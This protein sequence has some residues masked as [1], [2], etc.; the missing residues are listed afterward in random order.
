MADAVNP[1]FVAIVLAFVLAVPAS[2]R[3]AGPSPEAVVNRGVVELETGRAAGI[4][5][6]IAED[7]AN[8]VDDG[9]TRRVLPVIGAGTWQN[10]TDLKL[11]RGID[12]AI[13]QADVLDYARQ[14]NLYP[15]IENWLTYIAKL[16]NEEFHLLAGGNIKSVH[17]LANKK[18]N[19]DL[20]GAGTETTAARLFEL[21]QIPVVATNDDQE[22]ALEKLRR[23]EIAAMA[24][25][26]GKPAP[27]FRDLLG[28]GGLHFLSIPLNSAVTGA[29]A[30]ARLTAE[31]YPGLIQYNQ[32][33]DTV[34]VGAVLAA[35]NLQAPSERY[36]NLANF[37]NAFFTGF[38]S[39]LQPGHHPKWHEVNIATELPGWRRFPPAADW[40]Q[41]NAPAVASKPEDLK[42]IFTRFLDERQQAAGGTPLSQQ[43]KDQL[44]GQFQA[45]QKGQAH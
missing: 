27:I 28:D 12:M 3:T 37:V 40:L 17:D 29:Y 16:Y 45:W 7:L 15:G 38:Q 13:V 41:R 1:I 34:A 43:Q 10:L 18:V 39:L 8:V 35:A 42:A 31:D 30:P 20:R 9:A 44:F 23:G 4:S 33:V 24:F 14:Q 36:R 19:V 11:L 21:L 2:A 6:R 26:T 25:V 5:V 32:P 22:V